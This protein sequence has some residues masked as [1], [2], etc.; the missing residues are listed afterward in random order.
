[1]VKIKKNSDS[2]FEDNIWLTGQNILIDEME[3]RN[4]QN[5][6]N[7]EPQIKCRNVIRR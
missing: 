4:D 2:E 6:D 7:S 3:K 1:M 5:R